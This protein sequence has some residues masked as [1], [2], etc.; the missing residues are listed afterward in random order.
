MRPAQALTAEEEGAEGSSKVAGLAESWISSLEKKKKMILGFCSRVLQLLKEVRFICE[1]FTAC[2]V[3]IESTCR[4][5]D[6]S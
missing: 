4:Y 6:I 2:A 5:G 3:V 1:D